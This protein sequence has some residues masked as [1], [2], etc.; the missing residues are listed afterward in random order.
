[1]EG[2]TQ[3][4]APAGA[5]TAA[6]TNVDGKDGIYAR[7]GDAVQAQTGK[8]IGKSGGRKLFDQVVGEIFALATKEGSLRFNGG[9][10][11][12]HVREY[13]E[14]KRRLPSG[15]TTSF[16]KRRKV[17]YEEGVT[18]AALVSTKG[19]VP[20][21]MAKLAAAKPAKAS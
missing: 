7:L 17:R 8:R 15:Q 4:S 16:G 12:L 9:Y 1:M 10:G 13:K 18:A 11:S 21:A 20:A 5:T 2:N 3:A 19:D 14:G 6:E